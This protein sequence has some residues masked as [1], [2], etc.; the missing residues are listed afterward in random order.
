V[1]TNTAVKNNANLE[2]AAAMAISV[3]G[4]LV[5]PSPRAWDYGD[6][7]LLY[8]CQGWR[9]DKDSQRGEVVGWTLFSFTYAHQQSKEQRIHLCTSAK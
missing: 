9:E 2:E 1:A 3:G 4:M 7:S 8:C 5:S 6:M